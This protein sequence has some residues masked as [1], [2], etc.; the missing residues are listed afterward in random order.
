[1]GVKEGTLEVSTA[2]DAQCQEPAWFPHHVCPQLL[3][4]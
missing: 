3:A 4:Q 1:M 2:A